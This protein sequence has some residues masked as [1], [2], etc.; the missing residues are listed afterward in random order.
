MIKTASEYWTFIALFA[1]GGAA[2]LGMI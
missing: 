2:I 1:A